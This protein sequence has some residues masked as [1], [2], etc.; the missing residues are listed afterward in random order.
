MDGRCL[1]RLSGGPYDGMERHLPPDVDVLP[2]Y[3]AAVL[4]GA[5]G[6]AESVLLP[7]AYVLAPGTSTM[8]WVE[9][10]VTPDGRRAGGGYRS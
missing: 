7:G 8:A 4:H 3:E 2:A 1:R 5:D 10:P 6:T 9:T